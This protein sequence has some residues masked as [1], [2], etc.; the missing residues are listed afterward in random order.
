M[1]ENKTTKPGMGSQHIQTDICTQ[2][3]AQ[4]ST[5]NIRSSTVDTK[6]VTPATPTIRNTKDSLA[7]SSVTCAPVTNALS[8]A[9]ITPGTEKNIPVSSMMKSTPG[10]NSV[11]AAPLYNMV[12]QTPVCSAWAMAGSHVS[13]AMGVMNAHICNTVPKISGPITSFCTLNAMINPSFRGFAPPKSNRKKKK[14]NQ[15]QVSVGEQNKSLAEPSPEVAK[16]QKTPVVANIHAAPKIAN[17]QAALK[18]A[19]TQPVPNRVNAQQTLKTV[20]M[21][22]FTKAT[23]TESAPKTADT[24]LAAAAARIPPASKAVSTQLVPGVTYSQRVPKATDTQPVPTTAS[25]QLAPKTTVTQPSLKV[26]NVQPAA[27]AAGVHLAP[28]VANIKPASKSA[29]TQPASKDAGIQLASKAASTR[30]ASKVASHQPASNVAAVQSAPEVANQQSSQ[31]AANKLSAMK[32]ANKRPSPKTTGIQ[33]GLKVPSIQQAPKVANIQS[34]PKIANVQVRK[35]SDIQSVPKVTN[36]QPT[37]KVQYIHPA[38]PA[39][40]TKTIN[41]QFVPNTSLPVSDPVRRNSKLPQK[42]ETVNVESARAACITEMKKEVQQTVA[43]K[44]KREDSVNT[45][46]ELSKKKMKNE[47]NSDKNPLNSSGKNTLPVHKIGKINYV[48]KGTDGSNSALH[49]DTAST[50]QGCGRGRRESFRCEARVCDESEVAGSSANTRLD[51]RRYASVP[52]KP[53]I[54][55]CGSTRERGSSVSYGQRSSSSFQGGFK[56]QMPGSG[57]IPDPY[58]FVHVVM[59][60]SVRLNV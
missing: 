19:H 27:E 39:A 1:P 3:T 13:N 11:K 54:Y 25:T 42:V 44:R 49:I 22:P 6:I 18:V 58:V 23:N 17:T 24:Q 20:N 50:T 10:L 59:N 41:T 38:S 8:W 32:D 40:Y 21:Q 12:K 16:L 26:A 4:T 56:K 45:G 35:F 52:G 53:G 34:N 33:P 46:N 2:P 36:A 48:G 14:K 5:G 31:T 7:S 29:N 9:P 55:D 60:C 43:L 28:K 51:Q 15:Q 57:F 47:K 37:T 30:P